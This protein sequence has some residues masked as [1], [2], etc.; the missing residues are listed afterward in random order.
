M[1]QRTIS[2]DTIVIVQKRIDGAF[3]YSFSVRILVSFA[4]VKKVLAKIKYNM[5]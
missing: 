3:K 2:C 4:E 1:T 5:K